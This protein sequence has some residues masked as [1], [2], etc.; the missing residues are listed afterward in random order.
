MINRRKLLASG[1]AL[2]ALGMS[3]ARAH[4]LGEE[5]VL[6]EE[7]MPRE[8]RIRDD[9]EP[10]VVLVDPNQY[11]L[12]WTMPGQKAMRYTVGI[13]RGN[14]YHDGEFYVGRKVEWPD[15][16]PTPD[17]IKRSPDSYANFMEGGIYENGPQP[18]GINNPLGARA[19]Y[20]YNVRTRRDTYLRIH[21]TNNPRTI[22][23]AVSNG[24]ARLINPQVEELFALV[25]MGTRVVL[26]PKAGAGP[27]HS[28]V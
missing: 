9:F 8:V 27:A 23:V 12:F 21:G 17:M 2:G 6:P 22:G 28:E 26:Y 14:L 25:P 20:L 16:R 15:W 1:L 5:Y 18:G 4:K 24:C 19:L 7:F 13:G 3:P 11:A 10:G